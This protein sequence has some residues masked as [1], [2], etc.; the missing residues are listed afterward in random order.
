MSIS[1][2]SEPQALSVKNLS[3][4]YGRSQVLF[5]LSLDVAPAQ[6][7]AILG[8]NGAGKTTLLQT[9]MGEIA[10]NAGSIRLSD[11]EVSGLESAHRARRGLGY[12]PQDTPVFMRLSVR[13]NLLAG[14][15]N[16]GRVA[17]IDEVLALFPKL[18]TRLGQL[19][20]TLSGG[21]RKMLGICRALLGRPRILMLDEPTEGV[22]IGVIE[23]IAERLSELSRE[24]SIL[25]VE[26]HLDLVLKIAHRID[27][28]DRGRIVLSGPPGEVKSHPDFLR[29]LAP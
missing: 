18:C 29:L 22:W 25:I 12:V 13:D 9:L 17:D 15:I 4:G 24:M 20:G 7:V 5:G 27:V 8:R 28:M 21:E 1:S 3:A 19:A 6:T 2:V 23:E 26:Q 10:A 14:A 16:H 11:Q